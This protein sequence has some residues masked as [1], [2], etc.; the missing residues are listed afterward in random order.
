MG[1][2]ATQDAVTFPSC[3]R[4]ETGSF[5]LHAANLP[6]FPKP[7]FIDSKSVAAAWVESFNKTIGGPDVAGISNLFL[8]ESYWRDHLCLSWDLHCKFS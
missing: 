4:V 8:A 1:S 3:E 7:D 6:S 5:P 2:A